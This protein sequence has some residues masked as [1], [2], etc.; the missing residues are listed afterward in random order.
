MTHP[1]IEQA[2]A[3]LTDDD[4]TRIRSKR[5]AIALSGGGPTVGVTVGFLK[6]LDE[7]RDLLK[8]D[9]WTMSCVGAWAG[10]MYFL[11]DDPNERY[12]FCHDLM[13]SFYRPDD[14]YDLFPTP[15][16]FL[17][18]YPEMLQ[19]AF[20][21]LISPK[22]YR[23]LI[24]PSEIQRGYAQ[25]L[26]FYLTPSKWNPG[27][28]A[29]LMLNGILA[30]NPMVRL[31]MG[32]IYKSE[33]PGVSKLWFGPDYSVFN[34]GDIRDL[35]KRYATDNISLYHNAYELDASS[36]GSPSFMRVFSNTHEKDC[37]E[38]TFPSLCAC[39]GLPY[40]LSPHIFEGK[41][42][43]EGAT[44]DTIS[45]EVGRIANDDDNG[46]ANEYLTEMWVNRILQRTQIQPHRNLLQALQNL[47]M[48]FATTTA[49][50]NEAALVPKLRKINIDRDAGN[51]P[52]ICIYELTPQNFIN[53]D[54]TYSNFDKSVAGSYDASARYIASY[55]NDQALPVCPM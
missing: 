35:D 24:V 21:F 14:V 4:R 9:I 5:R 15:T 38:I 45:F 47:I 11:K 51:N 46:L 27:D 32:M 40:V 53:F 41:T 28:F 20:K 19:A 39:S 33:V 34:V 2:L 3:N 18:D 22:S 50:D 54:W 36:T 44:V 25:M 12:K 37:D 6:A 49:E 30:P 1:C 52:P 26:D 43:A 8:F 13:R 23:N 31:I 55:L 29:N 48:M 17:P 10:C 16:V 7:V 42:L